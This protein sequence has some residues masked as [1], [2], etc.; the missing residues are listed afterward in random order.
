MDPDRPGSLTKLPADGAGPPR[1][2][3]RLAL[4]SAGLVPALLA[5]RPRHGGATLEDEV[6]L[7]AS[8][9]ADCVAVRVDGDARHLRA[10]EQ[11]RPRGRLAPVHDLVRSGRPGREANQVP[12]LQ[13]LLAVGRAHYDG[14]L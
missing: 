13:G 5:V 10:R 1:L 9:D 14:A 2:R 7:F 11:Q 3:P 6:V 12:R 8:P 4:E